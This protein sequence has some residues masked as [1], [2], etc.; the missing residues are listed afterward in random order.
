VPVWYELI[1]LV[2]LFFAGFRVGQIGICWGLLTFM[3]LFV[4]FTFLGWVFW[5]RKVE[6]GE[7]LDG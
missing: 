5:V 4:L 7:A 2:V 6:I 3:G 1:T